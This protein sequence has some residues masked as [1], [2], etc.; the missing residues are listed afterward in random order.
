[1]LCTIPLSNNIPF[2]MII[3]STTEN[4]EIIA[5]VRNIRSYEAGDGNDPI[6]SFKDTWFI[7]INIA[8]TAVEELSTKGLLDKWGLKSKLQ[9]MEKE[10]GDHQKS[11]EQVMQ[12]VTE[13][14]GLDP[15]SI[16]QYT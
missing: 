2:F 12:E 8:A 4:T 1:M 3:T 15:Q 6:N 14:Q 16:R 11:I 13:S 7:C 9:G 10:A 5:A